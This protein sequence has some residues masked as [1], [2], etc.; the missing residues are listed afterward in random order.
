MHNAM[1]MVVTSSPLL[2]EHISGHLLTARLCW[3]LD[4]QCFRD[5]VSPCPWDS[6]RPLLLCHWEIIPWLLLGTM[7]SS[8][9]ISLMVLR[10]PIYS[11]RTDPAYHSLSYLLW[12]AQGKVI[13]MTSWV[14]SILMVW[15][16]AKGYFPVSVFS[17]SLC[18]AT[19]LCTDFLNRSSFGS[20]G[21][22]VV[23]QPEMGNTQVHLCIPPHSTS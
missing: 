7:S 5:F 15:P 22:H 21:V 11:V 2:Q 19:W 8:P 6:P 16:L 4:Y 10:N 12:N 9:P 17:L 18:H 20:H 3:I 14:R 1:Y 23:G 13:A